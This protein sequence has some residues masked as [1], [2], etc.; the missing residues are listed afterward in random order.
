M[1][2]LEL[3]MD[4]RDT[5]ELVNAL[6]KLI[7]KLEFSDDILKLDGPI[8][9]CHGNAIGYVEYER[10]VQNG[11]IR[12]GEGRCGT[13]L[14]VNC[15]SGC[16]ILVQTDWDFPGIAST[17]GWGGDCQ[18]IAGAVEYLDEHIGD[19]VEDPGYFLD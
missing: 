14:I 4:P 3:S 7:D 1:I 10:T 8:N 13:Y 9:D 2:K 19:E 11:M 12:L 16:D 6:R 18:D 15:D 5:Q 17:F